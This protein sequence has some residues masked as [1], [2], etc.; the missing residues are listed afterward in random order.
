MKPNPPA[1]LRMDSTTLKIGGLLEVAEA[2]QHAVAAQLEQLKQQTEALAQAVANVNA[3]ADDAV[4]A[5]EDAAGAAINRSIQDSLGQ[6]AKTAL[7][8]LQGV[9][10]PVMAKW[11]AMTEEAKA[12]EAQ[13]R[14][15]ISWFSWRWIALIGALGVGIIA[16]IVLAA[17]GLVWWEEFLINSLLRQRA[18]L[19][20]EVSRLEATAD[21]WS[22]KGGRANLTP[23]NGRLCVEV[24]ESAGRWTLTYD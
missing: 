12:A 5:L 2:Q 10:E 13:L 4:I 11:S 8:A 17:K 23:C 7:A 20:E 6:A 18:E 15:A 16:G 9:S 22:K 21:K 24:D 3:A 19:T 14:R 1:D